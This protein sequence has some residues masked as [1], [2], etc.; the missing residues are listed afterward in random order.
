MKAQRDKKMKG[1]KECK[2]HEVHSEKSI[3]NWRHTRK[4]NGAEEIFEKQW[5]RTIQN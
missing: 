3:Y 1:T 5:S 2:S 4:Q